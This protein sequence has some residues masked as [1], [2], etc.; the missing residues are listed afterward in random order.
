MNFNITANGIND[1]T[2]LQVLIYFLSMMVPFTSILRRKKTLSKNVKRLR[3][4]IGFLG[5]VVL[6]FDLFI[7]VL[8][9][10]N[11]EVPK[12]IKDYPFIYKY[13][14]VIFAY[15]FWLFFKGSVKKEVMLES[16]DF[17]K[18]AYDVMDT[19]NNNETLAKEKYM[20][21]DANKESTK[22]MEVLDMK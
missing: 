12:I 19:R 14:I 1:L 15:L 17:N 18:N 10:A 16:F 4:T 7:C 20:D 2:W 13:G 3:N 22:E 21:L 9:F 6:I 5:F 11:L 8:F